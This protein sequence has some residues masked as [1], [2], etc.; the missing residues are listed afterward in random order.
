MIRSTRITSTLCRIRLLERH[1]LIVP[2]FYEKCTYVIFNDRIGRKNDRQEPILKLNHDAARFAGFQDIEPSL[3]PL[4]GTWWQSSDGIYVS[5]TD[6]G[7][8]SSA[9]GPI[10]PMGIG[11]YQRS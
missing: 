5:T 2:E 11:C 3:L 4:A 9:T 8:N 7:T 6:T 1:N 10:L